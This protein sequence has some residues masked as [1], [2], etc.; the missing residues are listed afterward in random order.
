MFRMLRSLMTR[1]ARTYMHA[2][3]L[4]A[5]QLSWCQTVKADSAK[6]SGANCLG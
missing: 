2:A 1:S 5:D 3:R 6:H 4:N